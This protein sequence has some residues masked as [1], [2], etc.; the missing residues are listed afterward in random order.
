MAHHVVTSADPNDPTGRIWG[1][2]V[3]ALASALNQYTPGISERRA[4][5]TIGLAGGTH[6]RIVCAPR[7]SLLCS[8]DS[9]SRGRLSRKRRYEPFV[10]QMSHLH[11]YLALCALGVESGNDENAFLRRT[12]VGELH[13]KCSGVATSSRDRMDVREPVSSCGPPAQPA[14]TLLTRPIVAD[15]VTVSRR[16]CAQGRG[17]DPL[18]GRRTRGTPPVPNDSAPAVVT[19]SSNPEVCG[20]A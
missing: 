14:S 19:S 5:Y 20:M 11:S 9:C 10:T 18:C 4:V 7:M 17:D 2:M 1:W 3:L 13:S 6:D 16:P 12:F 15:G 8:S